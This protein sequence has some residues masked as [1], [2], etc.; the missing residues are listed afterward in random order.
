MLR[1]VICI[2]ATGL[3]QPACKSGTAEST[4]RPWYKTSG[5]WA[6]VG[7]RCVPLNRTAAL[8]GQTPSKTPYEYVRGYAG[9][10]SAGVPEIHEQIQK[11]PDNTGSQETTRHRYLHAR[12]GQ[13]LMLAAPTKKSC[14]FGKVDVRPASGS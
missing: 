9:L 13:R 10:C 14:E 1:F 7:N 5:G 12:C 4:A 2:L 11:A 8:P 6:L 3:L